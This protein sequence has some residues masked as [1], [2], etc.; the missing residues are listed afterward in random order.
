M[1]RRTLRWLAI[2]V[3]VLLLAAVLWRV[4]SARKEQQ[5]EAAKS[6]GQ[7]AQALVELAPSECFIMIR[8]IIGA[9]RL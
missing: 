8:K 9:I 5:D 6:A 2:G 1:N 7:K 4:V 3:A